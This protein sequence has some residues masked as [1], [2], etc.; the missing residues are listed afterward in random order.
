MVAMLHM[1]NLDGESREMLKK[2]AAANQMG[3]IFAGT[4]RRE[5]VVTGFDTTQY[6]ILLGNIDATGAKK[7]LSRLIEQANRQID[8]GFEI[9]TRLQALEPIS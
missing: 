3:A 8:M 4:L 2:Q 7:V 5:D 6:L 1:I 9:E